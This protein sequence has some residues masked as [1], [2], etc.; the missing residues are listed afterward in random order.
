MSVSDIRSDEAGVQH[1]EST[2][3][4]SCLNLGRGPLAFRNTYR[5]AVAVRHFSVWLFHTERPVLAAT[6]IL[7]FWPWTLILV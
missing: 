4:M 5:L 2:R 7:E 1:R 3:G 6:V